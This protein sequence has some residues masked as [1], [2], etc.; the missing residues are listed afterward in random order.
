MG[1]RRGGRL[2][3]RVG[4]D[5]DGDGDAV[6]AEPHPLGEIGHREP[7]RAAAGEDRA[8]LRGAEAVPVGLDHREDGS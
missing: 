7:V 1:E 2:R 8:H 4:I 3:E 6:L 5:E